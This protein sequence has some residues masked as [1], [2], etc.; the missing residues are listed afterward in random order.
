MLF[1]R[2]LRKKAEALREK[3]EC[4]NNN[5]LLASYFCTSA[6]I[7]KIFSMPSSNRIKRNALMAVC[8][9]GF[10]SLLCGRFLRARGR[11]LDSFFILFG[12]YMLAAAIILTMS[13]TISGMLGCIAPAACLLLLLLAVLY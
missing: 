8:C 2:R 12:V 5:L 7:P 3:A 1:R 4:I 13:L 10:L 11:V 9:V 6:Y